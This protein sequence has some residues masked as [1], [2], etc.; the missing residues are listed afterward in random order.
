MPESSFPQVLGE[1]SAKERSDPRWMAALYKGGTHAPTPI[2]F[3]EAEACMNGSDEEILFGLGR[4]LAKHL[5]RAPSEVTEVIWKTTRTVGMQDGPLSTCGKFVVIHRNPQNVFESQFRVSFGEGN[6]NP[7]RYAIFNESYQRAFDRIPP[8]RKFELH[9]DDLPEALNGLLEFLGVPDLGKWQEGRSAMAAV[10]EHCSWLSQITDEFQNN[11]VE[12]RG[13]LPRETVA[14]LKLA[15]Q[16]TR[17]LRSFL[18]PVR[19]HF[20]NRSLALYR[21][22]AAALLAQHTNRPSC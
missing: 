15:M 3:E 6:R 10:A 11:D 22:Q 16:L 20:D 13:R 1:L 18:G 17:P 2:T 8:G 7:L 5:G 4:K 14:R 12:K 21:R 9:Y 19:A